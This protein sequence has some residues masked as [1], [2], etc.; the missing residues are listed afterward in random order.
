MRIAIVQGVPQRF[1][2]ELAVC[3]NK[4]LLAGVTVIHGD[5]HCGL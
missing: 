1:S 5:E 2:C 3:A 4:W